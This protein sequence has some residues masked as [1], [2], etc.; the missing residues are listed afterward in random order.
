MP[1]ILTE[2]L[3]AGDVCPC[4]CASQSLPSDGSVAMPE[5]AGKWICPMHPD[6]VK[7][8]AGQCDICGMD[9]VTAESLGFVATASDRAAFGYSGFGGV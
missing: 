9:L 1:T 7:D 5:M 6:I 4:G 3:K 2:K 8:K